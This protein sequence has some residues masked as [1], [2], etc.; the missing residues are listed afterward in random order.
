MDRPQ[1][2]EYEPWSIN[3]APEV[4]H[5]S[6]YVLTNPKDYNR[7]YMTDMLQGVID[8]YTK[9]EVESSQTYL[10]LGIFTKKKTPQAALDA[11]RTFTEEDCETFLSFIR[12]NWGR[13]Y[14]APYVND[15]VNFCNT[16]K[17]KVN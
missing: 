6:L 7:Q 12:E 4:M 5:L 3:V 8:V 16:M 2:H 17:I 13:R 15:I 11:W 10:S 9:I 14:L 1:L